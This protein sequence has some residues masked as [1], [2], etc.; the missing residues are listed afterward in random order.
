MVSDDAPRSPQSIE[1]Q[2]SG[3][4]PP[5]SGPFEPG[6]V[7]SFFPSEV[8]HKETA[9]TEAPSSGPRVRIKH[10]PPRITPGRTATFWFAAAPIGVSQEC[11]IDHL[12]FHP[13]A[14]PTRYAQLAIGRHEFSVRVR[15]ASDPS[16]VAIARF[17]WWIMSRR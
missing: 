6:K 15:G 2:G 10:R 7:V 17:S 5:Q 3:T 16:E 9:G 1:I 14:A 13:C 8:D 12:G 4:T 11:E